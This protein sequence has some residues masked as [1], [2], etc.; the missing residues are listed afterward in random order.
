MALSHRKRLI[1]LKEEATYAVDP[2]LAA[3]NAK[4]TS[5]LSIRP[6][7]G[8]Y[9][10]RELVDGELGLKPE[11]LINVHAGV[12]F[13]SEA[14]GGGAA[15]TAPAW[16]EAALACGFAE[17]INAGVS[18]VY[19]LVSEVYSSVYVRTHIGGT[20]D[21]HAQ[22]IAG[23]RG[24]W[25]FTAN[26]NELPY[27]SFDLR[28]QFATPVK[29]AAP[30]VAYT[31]HVKPPRI[32]PANVT[33]FTLGGTTLRFRSFSMQSG[34]QI[35]VNRYANLVETFLGDRAITGSAVV[36]MP[37]L[38]SKDLIAMARAGTLEALAFTYGTT[39]GNI[40]SLAAPK[41]QV[42][43]AGEPYQNAE[44]DLDISLDLNFTPDT[45]DDEVAFTVT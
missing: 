41:V 36:Q 19:N 2:T 35:G 7:E 34:N 26:A 9:V 31:S 37:D 29:G 23:C 14:G 17:T 18:A 3:A 13:Q 1:L 21:G 38:A 24:T 12:T 15:G 25:G 27:W 43:L 20:T 40:V 44:G 42:K 33:A 10:N 8:Q 45:G 30:S 6:L 28:G 16:A 5:A 11:E 4:L 39:A 32:E 22:D